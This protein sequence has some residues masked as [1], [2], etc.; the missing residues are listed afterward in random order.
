MGGG[1]VGKSLPAVIG[2]WSLARQAQSVVRLLSVG[3]VA[4]GARVAEPAVEEFVLNCM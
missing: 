1:G 2:H 4:C 3:V